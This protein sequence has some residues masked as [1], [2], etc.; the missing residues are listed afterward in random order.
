M[1]ANMVAV[2]KI[3]DY[4]NDNAVILP[5]NYVQRDQNGSFIFVATHASKEYKAVKRIVKTGQIYNGLAEITDGLRPGDT[6]I[7]L[8]YLDVKEGEYVRVNQSLI[9]L[10]S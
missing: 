4:K 9:F 5:M 10:K 8:G 2:L 6:I 1:K 7:T 3:N